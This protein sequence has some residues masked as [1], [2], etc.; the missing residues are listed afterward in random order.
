V[1]EG[2]LEHFEKTPPIIEHQST[3]RESEQQGSRDPPLRTAEPSPIISVSVKDTPY[4]PVSPIE[5]QQHAPV[6]NRA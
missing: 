2:A 6:V 5:K 3:L 1:A 4:T